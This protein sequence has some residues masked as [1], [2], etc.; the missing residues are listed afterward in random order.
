MNGDPIFSVI[1]FLKLIRS[2][3]I[4]YLKDKIM[5]GNVFSNFHLP[6]DIFSKGN[7]LYAKKARWQ[8]LVVSLRVQGRSQ[9]GGGET[10]S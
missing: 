5:T 7:R 8:F 2:I 4:S 1:L 9:E 6:A 3:K 10:L